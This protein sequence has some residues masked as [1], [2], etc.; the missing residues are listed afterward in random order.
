MGVMCVR[1]GGKRQR[2]SI[3][4]ENGASLGEVLH[5]RVQSCKKAAR[6]G[7]RQN[8]KINLFCLKFGPGS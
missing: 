7:Q 4:V 1:E 6:V 3:I 8:A 5:S 2:K